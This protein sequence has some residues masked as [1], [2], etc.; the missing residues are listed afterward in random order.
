MRAELKDP[1][2]LIAAFVAFE[3]SEGSSYWFPRT[4]VHKLIVASTPADEDFQA[5]KL[6][7]LSFLQYEV[8]LDIRVT[9]VFLE[10]A[11]RNGNRS[12]AFRR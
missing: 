8:L 9:M 10:R 4:L 11:K 1:G 6:W 3:P 12:R 7:L 5:E 2:A